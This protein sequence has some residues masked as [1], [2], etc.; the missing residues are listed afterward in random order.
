MPLRLTDLLDSLG[1]GI[2]SSSRPAFIAMMESAQMW[3]RDD[4]SLL[5]SLH[6]ALVRGVLVQGQVRSAPMIVGQIGFEQAMQV[7]WDS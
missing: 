7:S 4:L 1:H 2:V 5:W 3:D 6:R